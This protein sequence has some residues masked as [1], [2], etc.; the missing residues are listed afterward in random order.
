MIRAAARSEDDAEQALKEIVAA[1]RK[2]AARRND[3]AIG[4]GGK[5]VKGHK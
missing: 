2:L 3:S 1:Q 5:R 4:L